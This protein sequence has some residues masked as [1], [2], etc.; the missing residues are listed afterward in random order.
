M[1]L[2]TR[3]RNNRLGYLIEGWD[4]TLVEGII[5]PAFMGIQYDD[6]TVPH[7]APVCGIRLVCTE[8]ERR[9][10]DSY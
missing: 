2:H 8:T 6:C 3:R 1:G 4:Y 5:D 10:G 7:T 9:I